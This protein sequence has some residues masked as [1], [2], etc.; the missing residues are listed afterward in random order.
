MSN[1]Y[2]SS[3]KF[4]CVFM[5]FSVPAFANTVSNKITH[6]ISVPASGYV[7]SP[8]SI[9]WS[10]LP[11]FSF[12]DF[13]F[14]K[15]GFR[16]NGGSYEYQDYRGSSTSM[17]L[18]QVGKWCFIIR[19]WNSNEDLFSSF[20]INNEKCVDIK[21][22]PLPKKPVLN[23]FDYYNPVNSNF[24]ISWNRQSDRNVEN[25]YKVNG[26][27]TSNNFYSKPYYTYGR[28]SI[29]VQACNKNDQCSE[30]TTVNFYVYSSP[31]FVKN[32]ASTKDSVNP[33]ESAV[34]SWSRPGGMIYNGFYTVSL[35]G[36]EVYSGT[37]LSFTHRST[38][39][40]E[41]Q[42]KIGACNPSLPCTE[43]LYSIHVEDNS[44]PVEIEGKAVFNFEPG[45]NGKII[46]PYYNKNEYLSWNVS[47]IK[48]AESYKV[49]IV[50][51]KN[52]LF[53]ANF[54]ANYIAERKI[55]NFKFGEE[56]N[57]K[58]LTNGMAVKVKLKACRENRCSQV[59]DLSST[60]NI[61]LVNWENNQYFK[62]S[63]LHI[64]P[65]NT[66]TDTDTSNI[67]NK[68]WPRAIRGNSSEP[69]SGYPHYFYEVDGNDV[70][71]TYM[72]RYDI[73]GSK[74]ADKQSVLFDGII[75]WNN[76]TKYSKSTKVQNRFD[77]T[78]NENDVELY[79]PLQSV[80]SRHFYREYL[81][82]VFGVKSNLELKDLNGNQFKTKLLFK[83]DRNLRRVSIFDAIHDVTKGTSEPRGVY[84]VLPAP[85]VDSENPYNHNLHKSRIEDYIDEVVEQYTIFLHNIS[86]KGETTN[87]RLAGF[88]WGQESASMLNEA[89][90]RK[91]DK[92]KCYAFYNKLL[93]DIKV[94]LSSFTIGREGE[95]GKLEL[96]AFVYSKLIAGGDKTFSEETCEKIENRVESCIERASA[97]RADGFTEHFD[98]VFFQPN[99]T[100]RRFGSKSP[101]LSE[102]EKKNPA[103]VAEAKLLNSK[104][105]DR[106][107]LD[108]HNRTL[109]KN[110]SGSANSKYSIMIEYIRALG[111]PIKVGEKIFGH[112]V[113]QPE[114]EIHAHFK[115]FQY[116]SY[117]S[118]LTGELNYPS[119][120][121]GDLSYYADYI[122]TQFPE[123]FRNGKRS[124]LYDDNGGLA[125]CYTKYAI[126]IKDACSAGVYVNA[127]F[128][129]WELV[130]SISELRS[131]Y[132]L[133]DVTR[134]AKN[135]G[136]STNKV[137][138][139]DNNLF[140]EE[141]IIKLHS[142]SR[143]LKSSKVHRNISISPGQ[144]ISVKS[145][146]RARLLESIA[147]R[148]YKPLNRDKENDLIVCSDKPVIKI[149]FFDANSKVLKTDTIELAAEE[150]KH[151]C[152][153]H[154]MKQAFYE[155][156]KGS[157]RP[158]NEFGSGFWTDIDYWSVLEKTFIAPTGTNSASIKLEAV[159]N[160]QEA[161][162]N[163]E[164]YL[165][166]R[167]EY[168][169]H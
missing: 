57:H 37:D 26:E 93:K 158:N 102:S 154:E 124:F 8:I 90:C 85:Y 147:F 47:N 134:S 127:K 61:K 15:V 151:A 103:L 11:G 6:S 36:S 137:F 106:E 132:S 65:I 167:P 73:D 25:Y 120:F 101:H 115:N 135:N 39:L 155:G 63:P 109:F 149:S 34:I 89:E 96:L 67:Y 164:A 40:G 169:V 122:M 4:L 48:N 99:A 64:V 16:L 68:L 45:S 32:L 145:L 77:N 139:G 31:G 112:T 166:Y 44:Q 168:K 116:S 157:A 41:H 98:Q 133:V 142:S 162:S 69:E 128:Y 138:K 160:T 86:E 83:P 148:R 21:D 2:F 143:E 72:F 66:E 113:S 130:E 152:L 54:D 82:N 55:V 78:F 79:A 123:D 19:A 24:S 13:S 92:L 75:A 28:K 100:T 51:S 91:G 105:V 1:F 161:Q 121:Y 118:R 23:G 59:S 3:F 43:S 126:G 9:Y 42:Y 125:Y 46:D 60:P 108:W 114:S 52:G 150:L 62:G 50:N 18:N 141:P 10:E 14:V 38:T 119:G 76:L 58:E 97:I 30:P 29:D 140:P 95:S 117:N 22:L 56:I 35:N 87:V 17:A 159:S 129:I 20:D 94:Y 110:L 131:L 80:N 7:G 53:L 27:Y 71:S 88:K 74:M 156:G 12:A 165:F 104:A 144:S 153:T 81:D 33:N 70:M 111:K 5:F 146:V 107:V 163:L 49:D 136:G 84:L